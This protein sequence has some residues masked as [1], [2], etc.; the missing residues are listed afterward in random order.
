MV[1]ASISDNDTNYLLLMNTDDKVLHT[2]T[3]CVSASHPP[4]PYASYAPPTLDR[5]TIVQLQAPL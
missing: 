5:L 4:L 3:P 2:Q 1:Y